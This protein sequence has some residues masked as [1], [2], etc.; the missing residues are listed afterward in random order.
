LHADAN[1]H[2]KLGLYRRVNVLLYLNKD[3]RAEFGGQLE[4][5]DREL[6]RRVRCVLPSF[7]RCVVFNTDSTSFHGHPVPLTCPAGV[8]RKSLAFYYF[9]SQ[10]YEGAREPHSVLWQP[11]P[12]T[13]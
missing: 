11:N 5:W 9:T 4:L 2:P 1:R 7:N 3:W 8:T 10:A 13:S 12:P 6:S